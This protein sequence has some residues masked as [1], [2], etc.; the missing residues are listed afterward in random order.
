M[1]LPKAETDRIAAWAKALEGNPAGLG[2]AVD[3]D[4]GKLVAL[5]L[6]NGAKDAPS[7]VVPVGMISNLGDVA[8]R[9]KGVKA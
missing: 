6:T 8:E 4:K 2:L 7:I 9:L 3:V 5:H 1:L